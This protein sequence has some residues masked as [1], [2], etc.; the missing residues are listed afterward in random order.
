MLYVVWRL[1]ECGI[2]VLD[3]VSKHVQT[4]FGSSICHLKTLNDACSIE[5][6]AR[7]RALDDTDNLYPTPSMINTEL[8]KR[9]TEFKNKKQPGR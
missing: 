4:F 2:F 9:Q 1:A 7:L 8:H 6:Q 3:C 5:I